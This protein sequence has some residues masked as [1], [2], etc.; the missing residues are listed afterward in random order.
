M[1]LAVDVHYRKDHAHV[2]GILYGSWSSPHPVRICC[3]EVKRVREYVPGQFYRRELP[4][5]L[6]LVRDH[7]LS[8]GTIVIDGYVYLDGV[9]TPGLGKHLYD[10]LKGA[11]VVVGVAKNRLPGVGRGHEILRGGSSRPLYVTAA[12]MKLARARAHIVSMHGSHRI[13]TLLKAADR[14]CRRR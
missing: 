8:P 13:P 14:A 1:M 3:S 6:T 10:A 7:G 2:A 5:I 4:C 11:A 9:A 12:G